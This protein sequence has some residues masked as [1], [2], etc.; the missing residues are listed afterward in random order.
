MKTLK[1]NWSV[2]KF[3]KLFSPSVVLDCEGNETDNVKVKILSTNESNLSNKASMIGIVYDKN[4]ENGIPIAFSK[5]G[6]IANVSNVSLKIKYKKIEI[7]DILVQGDVIYSI[8]DIHD[9]DDCTQSVSSKTYIN[10]KSNTS[11]NNGKIRHLVLSK[12]KIPS[13]QEK[14][15]L[16]NLIKTK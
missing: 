2:E 9:N 6:K 8:T 4:G 1:T 15:K 7:G 13:N 10:E 5:N 16:T 12:C 11:V 3:E 14:E